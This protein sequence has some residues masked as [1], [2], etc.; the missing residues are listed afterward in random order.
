MYFVLGLL[1]AGLLALVIVP[2]FWRRAL[3]L[4]RARIEASIPMTRAE[5]EADKDQLRASFAIT[6]RRLEMESERL[7]ERL[8][9]E[10]ITINR[11]SEEVA[12]LTRTKEQLTATIGTMDVRIGELVQE[13]ADRERHL[14]DAKAAV[15]ER[16]ARISGLEQALEEVRADLSTSQLMT[17]ELRL[18]MVARTTEIG[19]L[20]DN[21]A[22]LTAA[23]AAGA[24]AREALA[25]EIA[26]ERDRL[27]AER[28]RVEAMEAGIAVLQTERAGRAAELE[29]RAAEIRALEADLARE[30]I[31]NAALANTV[32]ALTLERDRLSASLAAEQQVAEELGDGLTDDAARIGKLQKEL[33]ETERALQEARVQLGIAEP[34]V[35]DNVTKA[36]AATE[37][38]RDALNAR[39]IQMEEAIADLRAENAD[40]RRV[41]GPEWESE[42]EETR[43]LRER[44]G[45]IASAVARMS[46]GPA[47]SPAAIEAPATIALAPASR[48]PADEEG[49]TLAERVRALQHAGAR[50]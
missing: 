26:G 2:A 17:E 11:W 21:V 18:E 42:R 4:A 5:I 24:A 49:R 27:T 43:R 12:S 1:A 35:G 37:A 7:R 25:A 46:G 31:T 6:N 14:A 48:S 8:S 36:I 3:R 9:Q 33:R 50:H 20:G 13:V 47:P 32:T 44:L 16:E 15:T 40:L 41:A 38:E 45:E 23:Q 19:N 39:L 29:R 34:G 28:K 30:R 22:S 10:T